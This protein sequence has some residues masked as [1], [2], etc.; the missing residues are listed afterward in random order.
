MENA[1][2]PKSKLDAPKGWCTDVK[3]DI[4]RWPNSR[5]VLGSC[6]M[7]GCWPNVKGSNVNLAA[8]IVV[9]E[10]CY[11]HSQILFY[12]NLNLKNSWHLTDTYVISTWNIT[13]SLISLNSTGELQNSSIEHPC[14]HQMLLRWKKTCLHAWM[15]FL[16][17]KWGGLF[18]P[19]ICYLSFLL[20]HVYALQ[21]CKPFHMFH[22]HIWP[23]L[24]WCWSSLG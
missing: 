16:F 1:K 18:L 13:V 17:F 6:P 14:A 22:I 4:S 2:E 10:G 24:V 3:C 23:G 7:M 15:M 12:R 8:W 19:S 11:S 9:V 20:I 21:I 5:I